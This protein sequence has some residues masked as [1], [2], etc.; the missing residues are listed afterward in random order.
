MAK[1][2]IL[3]VDDEEHLLKINEIRLKASGYEVETAN[4]GEKALNKARTINPDIIILDVML[5]KLDGYKICQMLKFDETF[6]HIPIILLTARAQESD[7]A[8]GLQTGADVF[9]T[10][11]FDSAELLANIKRLVNE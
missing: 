9:M 6:S 10:K 5:P 3:L 1:K 4:D 2:L 7:K 11:P 8:I